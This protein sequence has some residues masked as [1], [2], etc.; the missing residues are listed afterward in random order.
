MM[1]IPGCQRSSRFA[2]GGGLHRL[3]AWELAWIQRA[4]QRANKIVT[5]N[6]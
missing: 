6:A 1:E 5:F 3:G 4:G 2:A